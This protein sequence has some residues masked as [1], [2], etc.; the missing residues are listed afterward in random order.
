MLATTATKEVA[1]AIRHR[2]LTTQQLPLLG[3]PPRTPP[4]GGS[5]RP[6]RLLR[7]SQWG[8]HP[9]AG[10]CQMTDLGSVQQPL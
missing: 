5:R 1:E 7:K 10:I 2:P 4:A 6:F 3:P 8:I 9:I